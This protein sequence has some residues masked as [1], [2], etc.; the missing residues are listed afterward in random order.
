LGKRKAIIVT[1]IATIIYVGLLSITITLD[2]E[3]RRIE[4]SE[5]EAE[6]VEKVKKYLKQLTEI[7]EVNESFV[8]E[9]EYKEEEAEQKGEEEK[10]TEDEIDDEEEESTDESKSNEEEGKEEEEEEKPKIYLTFD[11][12]PSKYLDEILNTLDEHQV[13]G[14]FFFIGTILGGL[15]DERIAQIKEGEHGVGSHTWT[16]DKDNVYTQNRFVEENK[17]TLV[18]LDKIGLTSNIIR[19]PYGSTYMSDGQI[20][21]SR[22]NGWKI[23]DWHI[24]SRDWELKNAEKAYQRVLSQLEGAQKKYE[25]DGIVILFHENNQTV[26]TLELLIPELEERGFDLISEEQKPMKEHVFRGR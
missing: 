23:I 9:Q 20:E 14:T 12:G 17:R 19:A 16:H 1:I 21:D 18:E 15:S 4:T 10:N 2:N 13:K 5:T 11:D 3:Q 25:E 6:E 22:N 26:K 7:K 8:K 24:D